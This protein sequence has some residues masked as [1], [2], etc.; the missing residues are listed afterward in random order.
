[1]VDL[2]L[3]GITATVVLLWLSALICSNNR[4][5]YGQV[6]FVFTYATVFVCF[7]QGFIESP[8]L[9]YDKTEE[10]EKFA[11]TANLGFVFATGLGSSQ[12]Q[13]AKYTQLFLCERTN[14]YVVSKNM[15]IINENVYPTQGSEII[16]SEAIHLLQFMFIPIY[17][18]SWFYGI[19]GSPWGFPWDSPSSSGSVFNYGLNPFNIEFGNGQDA[20]EVYKQF[21]NAAK[22]HENIVLFGMSKGCSSII[23]ALPKIQNHHHYHKVKGIVLESPFPSVDEIFDSWKKSWLSP[24]VSLFYLFLIKKDTPGSEYIKSGNLI[25]KKLY[26]NGG[27]TKPLKLLESFDFKSLPP[28][29]VI[30][31]LKDDVTDYSLISQYKDLIDKNK[32]KSPLSRFITLNHSKHDLYAIQHPEDRKTYYN[33]IHKF[34]KDIGIV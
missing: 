9:K 3:I 5:I 25:Q 19:K 28:L 23:H 4:L 7:T 31:S 6:V 2:F 21:E 8:V 14:Q 1:M 12:L 30:G 22:T 15:Q 24:I 17:Y 11:K 29:F 33:E 34:Y 16:M 20:D 10:D 18:K 32:E 26:G 13:A 27:Y